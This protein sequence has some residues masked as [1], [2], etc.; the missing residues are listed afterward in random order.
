MSLLEAL[1]QGYAATQAQR[2]TY[3]AGLSAEDAA[4]QQSIYTA[5]DGKKTWD[6]ENQILELTGNTLQSVANKRAYELL[7]LSASDQ[8]LQQRIWSLQDEAV[9]QQKAADAYKT[10]L[11]AQQS[12]LQGLVAF[13][14]KFQDF[15]N[16][17]KVQDNPATSPESR[18]AAAKAQYEADLALAKHGVDATHTQEQ[19]DAAKN[20]LTTEAQTYLDAAKNYYASGQGYQDIIASIKKS[21]EGMTDVVNKSANEIALAA[22]TAALTALNAG[23]TTTGTGLNA[24]IGNAGTGLNALIAAIGLTDAA[25][26]RATI[27]GLKDQFATVDLN[28]NGSLDLAEFTKSLASSRPTTMTDTDWAAYVKKLYDSINTD[29]TGTEGISLLEATVASKN[30]LQTSLGQTTDS[31]SLLWILTDHTKYLWSIRESLFSI[32]GAV[33]LPTNNGSGGVNPRD[34]QLPIGSTANESIELLRKIQSAVGD[35]GGVNMLSYLNRI[36]QNTY[37]IANKTP[38]IWGASSAARSAVANAPTALPT[39]PVNIVPVFRPAAPAPTP[40]PAPIQDNRDIIVELKALIRL[41]QAANQQ[42]IARVQVMGE[43]IA[44]LRNDM[45]LTEKNR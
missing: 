7:S 14:Q 41:Q 42:L 22:T 10:A 45:A 13:G 27:A 28:G 15:L 20:R 31:N 43:H 12:L 30:I 35:N 8:I 19:I 1:G 17:L 38:A 33:R 18:L 44:E 40:E 5:Q 2:A 39:I 23:I 16:G 36:T 6:L 21:L 37:A 9:A 26:L 24:I 11:T 25:G 4:L 34:S 3:L 29:T 32:D